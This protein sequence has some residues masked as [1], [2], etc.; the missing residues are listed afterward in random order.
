MKKVFLSLF[1]AIILIISSCSQKTNEVV[2]PEVQE[3]TRIESNR[4]SQALIESEL[5]LDYM[6]KIEN[7]SYPLERVTENLSESE[8]SAY[9]ARLT[10]SIQAYNANPTDA[11]YE[12]VATMLGFA[13]AV[14]HRQATD[15]AIRSLRNLKVNYAGFAGLTA[16]V[17][18]ATIDATAEQYELQGRGFR[19]CIRKAS[20]AYIKAVAD[21]A[22]EGAAWD[23]FTSD[24]ANCIN[25]YL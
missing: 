2:L 17:I 5:F 16:S 11:N 10:S 7:L 4:T 15:E 14:H 13:S 19:R 9:Y 8:L 22:D 12:V 23:T 21:G 24:V 25:T 1:S 18:D 20:R 3:Q 6:S